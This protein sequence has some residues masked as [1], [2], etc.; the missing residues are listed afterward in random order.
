MVS[1][2]KC[3]SFD[4]SMTKTDNIQDISLH[5]EEDANLSLEESL[6]D[7]FHPGTLEGENAYWC[8]TCQTTCRAAKNLSYTRTP[9]ILIIHLKRLILG[10]KIRLDPYFLQHYPRFGALRDARTFI[11]PRYETG[12]HHFTPWHERQWALHSNDETRRQM[13]PVQ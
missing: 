6:Y 2:V 1:T 9:T 5:I 12:R 3:S 11:T 10:K 4:R 13:D 7:F 8:D